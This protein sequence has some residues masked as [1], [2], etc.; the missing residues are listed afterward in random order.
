MTVPN[1]LA[2]VPGGYRGRAF[3]FAD[4]DL[5]SAR[6]KQ[7]QQSSLLN[8]SNGLKVL[9]RRKQQLQC[10]LFAVNVNPMTAANKDPRSNYIS[11]YI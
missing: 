11:I 9:S 10:L 3:F 4:L 5:Y 1:I 6:A 8:S 7:H 2:N